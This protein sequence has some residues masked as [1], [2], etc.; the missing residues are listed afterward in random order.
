MTG[1][2]IRAT[3]SAD[4]FEPA[5]YKGKKCRLASRINPSSLTSGILCAEW[6][7]VQV[8]NFFEPTAPS[9]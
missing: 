8:G 1:A 7:L 4:D 2:Q 6:Q 3:L 5:A 9:K